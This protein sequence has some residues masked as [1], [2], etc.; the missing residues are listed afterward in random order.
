[1]YKRTAD[2]KQSIKEVEKENTKK[3][4]LLSGSVKIIQKLKKFYK[5]ECRQAGVRDNFKLLVN[6][7]A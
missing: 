7:F 5:I 4:A 3:E 1:M 2:L 6:D